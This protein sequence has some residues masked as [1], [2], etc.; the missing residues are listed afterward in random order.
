M[1]KDMDFEEL[2]KK[3]ADSN[4][5]NK[6]ASVSNSSIRIIKTNKDIGSINAEIQG[7]SIVPYKLSIDITKV[8]SY[9]VI[10]HNCP[11][12]L[13]RKKPNN[14][15][16]KHIAKF[17]LNLNEQDSEFATLLL[18]EFNLK[19]S[20]Q[21]QISN[22]DLEDIN[23]FVNK[24]LKNQL[25]FDYKGF[26]FFFELSELGDDA[27]DCLKEILME[28]KRLPA[29]LKGF[30]GGY[31]GGLFD[32]ILLVTNYTYIMGKSEEFNVDIKKAILTAI[33]HDFGKISY[34]S[35]KRKNIISKIAVTRDELDIIHEEI[36]NKFNY[37]G[38]DYH[39]EEAVAVI[40]NQIPLLFFDDEMYKAIIFHH[41]QWSKY[42]PIEMS[43]LATLIHTAD[44]IASQTHFV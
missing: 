35:F 24:D 12:F 21:V 9:D 41:G 28:A 8:N 16:C 6:A 27:R 19:I 20:Q 26:D 15:F 38:R 7:N 17:F 33:Y 32:H 3:F 5:I 44:M 36:S 22:K 18:S 34:Y 11:D 1:P 29:A 13:A 30:H 42:Y 23:H 25:D 37:E 2:F 10:N 14:K 39:V 31:D 43:E 40:K 4:T